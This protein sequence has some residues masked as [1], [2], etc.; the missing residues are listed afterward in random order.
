MV[1]RRSSMSSSA[2]RDL[3]MVSS[4]DRGVGTRPAPGADRLVTSARARVGS[5][6]NTALRHIPQIQRIPLSRVPAPPAGYA[7]SS[8]DVASPH[9]S[10]SLWYGR[11]RG[12][13][14]GHPVEWLATPTRVPPDSAARNRRSRGVR[15]EGGRLGSRSAAG[16]P[17]AD[18]DPIQG[19]SASP[20]EQEPRQRQEAHH[21]WGVMSTAPRAGLSP[22]RRTTV[23]HRPVEAMCRQPVPVRRSRFRRRVRRHHH[24][25]AVA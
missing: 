24:A 17:C 1:R 3:G 14:L 9:C 10:P 16:A 25:R 4:P 22:V 23:V 7:R 5:K 2:G 20:S 15:V 12:A 6:R 8:H 21:W 18:R 13:H 11:C 19:G